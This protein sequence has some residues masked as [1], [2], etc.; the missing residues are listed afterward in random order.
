MSIAL[1]ARRRNRDRDAGEIAIIEPRGAGLRARAKE[2]WAYRRLLR[3]FGRRALEKMYVRT[4]LGWLWIVLRPLL[5][6]TSKALVFGGLLNAPAPGAIP[7]FL[8]FLVGMGVWTFFDRTLMWS[9]RSIE[10]NRKLVGKMYFPR[11]ILPIG[12]SVPGIV[13]FVIYVGLVIAAA[14]VYLKTRGHFFLEIDHRFFGALLAVAMIYLLAIG[15]GLWTSVLGAAKRDVRFTLG[16]I[17]SFWYFVTPVIYPMTSIPDK[18][19]RI[20]TLNPLASLVEAVRYGVL[21]AGQFRPLG[22]AY[23]GAVIVVL[24]IGGLW[25]FGRAEAASVDQ[26]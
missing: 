5:D 2:V 22:L 16:Y 20:A 23:A 18:Y 4:R 26:L 9:T 19:Q 21:G 8:F 15:I 13:D 24:W 11:L 6:T 14:L 17:L 7:Y 1:P 10:L 3:F 25:F 12:G